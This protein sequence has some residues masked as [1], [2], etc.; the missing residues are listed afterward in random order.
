MI[1]VGVTL[2]MRPGYFALLAVGALIKIFAFGFNIA[3]TMLE[4]N[5]T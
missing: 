1:W 4:I 5:E 3:K 2:N